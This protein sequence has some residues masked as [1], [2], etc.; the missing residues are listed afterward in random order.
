MYDKF[1]GCLTVIHKM[2]TLP[3]WWWANIQ[4]AC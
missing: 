3:V 4:F 1:S 2:W